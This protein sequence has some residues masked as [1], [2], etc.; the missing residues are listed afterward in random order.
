MIARKKRWYLAIALVLVVAVGIWQ[1]IPFVSSH[2][3]HAS[4]HQKGAA[5]TPIQ[6]VV[7]IM[8]ENHTFDN[9]F[10]QYPGA[11][12]VTLPR[13]SDPVRDDF[14]HDA[15]GLNAAEDGGKMDQFPLRG[16]IQYTQQDIPYYWSYAQHYGLGDN[17]FTSM[18]SSSAP[19]HV[20][21]IAA[22]TGGIFD[23][24]GQKGCQST[25]NNL[26]FSKDKTTSNQYWSYPCYNIQSL[27]NLLEPAGISWRF[28]SEIPIWDAPAMIQSISGSPN[29]IHST[30]QFVKDVQAGTMA[31][32]SW[33]TPAG[34]GTDHSP[35][36]VEGAQNFVAQQVNAVMNSQ[37]WASTAIFVTWDDWGG[38][39]DHVLP[40]VVDGVG[41][42]PRVPLLVISPYAKPG[43]IS[44]QQGEF[45]SF[46]KFTEE[47]FGLGNLGQRDALPQTSDLMDY[48][49]FNQTQP[50][51]IQGQLPAS[52]ALRVPLDKKNGLNGSVNPEI[53]GPDTTFKFEILYTLKVTPTT[54]E[55]TIDGVNYPMT[56]AGSF[57]GQGTLY[58]YKTK[59][60]VGSHSCSFTFST[61]KG[62][63]TTIPYNGVPFNAPTV[64]PFDL[65]TSLSAGVTLPN[66]PV[67]YSATYISPTNT[68][69]TLTEVE[70]D[71]LPETMVSSGGT[72]YSKGVKYTYTTTLSVGTHW[73]RFR[74]NDGSGVAIYEGN[75]APQVPSLLL[76]QS[77]VSPATGTASTVFTFQAT[78]TDAAGKPPTRANLYVDQVAYPMTY[79]SGSYSTGALY[80]VQTTLPVSAKHQFYYVFADASQGAWAYP[81]SPGY[82]AGPNNTGSS[83][84]SPK[85]GTLITPDIDI[86]DET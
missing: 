80:Q 61:S 38:F 2:Y 86:S 76:T 49:D 85:T 31:D 58:I 51:L 64:S 63:L 3:I 41:L 18:A 68:R 37:Y 42:G 8:M 16:Q 44:H 34:A 55:V 73:Y 72:N 6:H 67:T 39:Y 56:S 54:S 20:A 17:F 83:V 59:L 13:A 24:K 29:D 43:Y 33:I 70:I 35:S 22:Q 25:Q 78:Y 14:Y 10:G 75:A 65:N 52:F 47:D 62:G 69:P 19:N 50:P 15:A 4:T 27:P 9:F 82:F 77:S 11:N 57:K 12:G 81:F 60:P 46:V 74:F 28:Y 84:Q 26:I 40:P 1:G 71:G 7:V 48:F 45:S 79:V 36:T 66:Q 23:S 30:T 53:G 21:M 32:V 5:T